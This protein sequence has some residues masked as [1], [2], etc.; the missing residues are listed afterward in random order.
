MVGRLTH[1]ACQTAGVR[2]VGIA[3]CC[4]AIGLAGRADGS[5]ATG[6]APGNAPRSV[7]STPSFRSGWPCSGCIVEVPSGYRRVRPASLV[8]LLHG[9]EGAPGSIAS[10]FGPVAAGRNVIVFAPHCPVALG[11]RFANGA[12]GTTSSWWGWLQYGRTYDDGWLGRQISRVESTYAINRHSEYLIGWSGG[13]DYL[14][15]YALQDSS[16]FAAVAFVAGGVPYHASCPATHLAAYFLLGGRDPRYLT[17]QPL[18][19]R[20]IFARCG[21]ATKVVVIPGQDHEGTMFSLSTSGYATSLLD[22]LLRHHT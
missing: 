12:D 15:W 19:V 9:D 3:V 7:A 16:R 4:V 22:W 11:C 10:V 21:D 14:G 17:G 6:T 2:F 1:G 20:S 18:A 8:I 5:A 13:A